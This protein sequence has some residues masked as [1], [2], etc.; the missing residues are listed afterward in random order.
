MTLKFKRNI[1]LVILTTVILTTLV[2]TFGKLPI[3]AYGI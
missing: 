1:T 2:L 3:V